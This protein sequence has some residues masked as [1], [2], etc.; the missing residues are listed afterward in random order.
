MTAEPARSC[1]K[2]LAHFY[3]TRRYDE[4]H[5]FAFLDLSVIAPDG[6]EPETNGWPGHRF[7]DFFTLVKI[8]HEWEILSKVFHLHPN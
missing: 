6:A 1:G 3:R 4:H 5:R 7:T 8:D 2:G